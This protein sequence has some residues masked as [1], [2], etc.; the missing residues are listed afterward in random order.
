MSEPYCLVHRNPKIISSL[1]LTPDGK[2]VVFGSVDGKLRV[3]EILGGKLIREIKGHMDQ[4]T[5]VCMTPDGTRI[6]SGS[7]DKTVRI[8]WIENGELFQK[9]EGHIDWISY[10]RVTPDGKYVVSGAWDRNI[11]ITRVRDGKL[12]HNIK[13]CYG[14]WDVFHLGLLSVTPDS[15]HIITNSYRQCTTTVCIYR[16]KT[17]ELIRKI[18]KGI[19]SIYNG[20]LT[21]NGEH[22]VLHEDLKTISILRIKDATIRKLENLKNL[23]NVYATPDSKYIICSLDD[24]MHIMRI[25]DGKLVH[26]FSN[27]FYPCNIC[28]TR[29]GKHI[30]HSSFGRIA[31][32]M[33]TNPIYVQNI[34]LLRQWV[35]IMLFQQKDLICLSKPGLQSLF[36]YFQ[37]YP[38]LIRFVGT[39]LMSLNV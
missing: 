5:S 3:I 28:V 12:L 20:F 9:M 7:R 11:C 34:R 6:V 21:P 30:L 32:Y 1:F 27:L 22:L 23:R 25:K 35:R 39:K 19:K 36:A 24:S 14:V 8:T 38:G 10:V 31:I 26:Q 16:I 2:H 15:K 4:V 13:R 37:M 17:G 18:K 29:N 33:N